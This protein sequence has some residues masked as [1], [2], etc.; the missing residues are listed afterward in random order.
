MADN[1]LSP[2]GG[3]T[4]LAS[5]AAAFAM[6]AVLRRLLAEREDAA[7]A[8]AWP[9]A[10]AEDPAWQDWC[11]AWEAFARTRGLG[12]LGPVV[13]HV[14]PLACVERTET[15]SGCFVPA[16]PLGL[17][18]AAVFPTDSRPRADDWAAL[19]GGLTE[20]LSVLEPST[21]AVYAESVRALSWVYAHAVG[22]DRDA[23]H[24]ALHDVAVVA[25]A[26]AGALAAAWDRAGRVQA[27]AEFLGQAWTTPVLSFVLLDLTGIQASLHAV[28]SKHAARTLRGKSLRIQLLNDAV[29]R[30]LAAQLGVPST[31]VLYASGGRGWLLAPAEAMG[32]R[33]RHWAARVDLW[34]RKTTGGHGGFAVGAAPVKVNELLGPGFAQVWKQAER[35]L[36]Q[37]RTRPFDGLTAEERRGAFAPID[38][39]PPCAACGRDL[40]ARGGHDPQRAGDGG[41]SAAA[42][43]GAATALCPHCKQ[44]ER[45]GAALPH[46]R[47]V[48]A[49]R[50][51]VEVPES[52][53]RFDFGP[54]VGLAYHLVDRPPSPGAVP[55]DS[56]LVALDPPT[57]DS[58]WPAEGLASALLL[59]AR[60]KP[61]SQRGGGVATYDELAAGGQ[62]PARLGVLRADVDNLGATF[63][64]GLL[65]QPSLVGSVALSRALTWFFSGH[66]GWLVDHEP[67][68]GALQ[69]VF[70]GG[71]DVFLVGSWEHLAVL[72]LDLRARF[73]AFSGS[74]RAV[75]FSAGLAHG[76]PNAPAIALARWA[77]DEEERAKE[78]DRVANGRTK[79]AF[80]LLGRVLD[81]RDAWRA[82][83][84]ARDLVGLIGRTK[85]GPLEVLPRVAGGADHALFQPA[86]P[87]VTGRI[88]R[89]FL[90]RLA[91]VGIVVREAA[92]HVHQG[93]AQQAAA[94][95]RHAWKWLVAY[96]FARL[97][98]RHGDG[99][100][101]ALDDLQAALASNAYR[102]VQGERDLVDFV[103]VAAGW[104][105][106][107]TR[108]GER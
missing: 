33:V 53:A 105:A 94:L 5:A 92:E 76:G 52:R 106:Q 3:A 56:V 31:C 7:H 90:H 4:P 10:R 84:V 48:V 64:K 39:G 25:G 89:G 23:P 69:V 91:R 26:L 73:H 57:R 54:H 2:L 19:A 71:D 95:A 41:E 67:Y 24:V 100:R 99:V 30:A 35:A 62:G 85:A 8:V 83:V 22:S 70:A 98:E 29:A 43:L 96:W 61:D 108:S 77:H 59:V 63:G 36:W 9:S 28:T 97:R 55:E 102:G 66:V 14:P 32:A 60:N 74:N 72:A 18:D 37:A 82:A 93:R 21:P 20:A 40:T 86:P 47:W 88:A 68:A 107:V 65:G 11:E 75:T 49:V 1:G 46:A 17:D 87:P 42:A 81:W 44:A 104:A 101:T 16:R 27:P 6:Q 50:R 58:R 38:E 34:R 79:D 15:P 103:D 80:V 45:A 13:A 51:R 78:Y 12:G